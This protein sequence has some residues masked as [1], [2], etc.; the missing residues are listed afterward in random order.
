MQAKQSVTIGRPVGDVFVFVADGENAIQWR[1]G[2]LDVERVS[3]DGGVGTIYRQGVKGPMGRRIAADYEI[4]DFEPDRLIAFRA[5]AGPFRP[6]GRF[7]FEQT[8]GRTRLTLKLEGELTGL[9]KLLMGRAVWKTMR[10]EARNLENI[11]RVL[12]S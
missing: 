2:V 1:P 6:R 10:A 3:G 9:R 4:T 7:E 5:T 11:K 12:E 8:D